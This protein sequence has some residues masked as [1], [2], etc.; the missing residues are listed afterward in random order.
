MVKMIIIFGLLVAAAIA[1]GVLEVAVHPERLAG[2]PT[3][4]LNLARQPETL[5]RL[6]LQATEWKREAERFIIRD[7]EERM[8]IAVMYVKEDAEA[9]QQLLDSENP[10]AQELLGRARLL[11]DSAKQMQQQLEVMPVE[12]LVAMRTP[13][14]EARAAVQTVLQELESKRD[15]YA[16]IQEQFA[17]ITESLQAQGRDLSEEIAP[18]ADVAGTSDE[19]TPAASPAIPLNF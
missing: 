2:A 17:L 9:L 4:L 19:S 6:K 3:A 12:L 11:D 8:K 16:V 18:E 14:R 10:P 5:A 1:T 13:V 15:H 7:E